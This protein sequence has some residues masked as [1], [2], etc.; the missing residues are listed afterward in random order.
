VYAGQGHQLLQNNQI[1][2][3]EPMFQATSEKYPNQPDGLAGLAAI[4]Q[5]QCAV[6]YTDYWE[7]YVGV[8]PRNRYRAVGKESGKT[9]YIERLN[10]TFRPR[11]SRLARKSLSFSKSLENHLGAIGNFTHNYNFSL[12]A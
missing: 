1:N 9:S 6:V 8:I 11:I 3:A 10:G 2:E 4:A 7:A 5:R 12:F